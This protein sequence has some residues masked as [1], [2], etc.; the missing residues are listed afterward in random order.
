MKT[1]VIWRRD[2]QDVF[3]VVQADS[4]GEAWE[5]AKTILAPR[6][7]TTLFAGYPI[8]GDEWDMIEAITA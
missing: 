4:V 7:L 8:L 5:K 6:G 3:V 1:Y 2:D